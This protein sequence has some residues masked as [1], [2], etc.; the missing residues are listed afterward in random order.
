MKQLRL[1]LIV[2]IMVILVR[3]YFTPGDFEEPATE[4]AQDVQVYEPEDF[5][6]ELANYYEY[7][8]RKGK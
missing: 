2:I 3:L 5:Y 4:V 1:L 8:E 7:L 6:D